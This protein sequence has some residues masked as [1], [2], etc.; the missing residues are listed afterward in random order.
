MAYKTL[1]DELNTRIQDAKNAVITWSTKHDKYY[2]LR[3][4]HK[5]TKNFP[6]PGS[7]NLR[8]PTIEM[9]I[10][11][12][13]S[14]LIGLYSNI[15][16]RVQVIPQSDTDLNKANKIEKFLDWLADY[17][18]KLLE[19]LILITD[20]MLE[21]GFCIAEVDWR[22][23]DDTRTEV[24]SLDDLSVDE[25]M[26]VF[27]LE[28]SDDMLMQALIQKLKVDTSE[29]VVG[30]NLEELAKV[31]EQI[32]SGKDKIK[33]TLKDELY[34]APVVNVIDPAHFFVNSDAGIDIQKLRFCGYEFYEP[35]ENLKKW[36]QKGIIDKEALDNIDY[37]AQTGIK[38]DKLVETTKDLH[39]GIQRLNNPSHLVKLYKIFTYYD[40]D[41]D[42]VDE[43][44]MFL[45]APEF[46]EV[47]K[48]TA[49]P[50]DH[51]K[52]P[53]IRFA[54][55]V[56]DDRWYS[57]RGI[58]AHLE[59]ISKEIDA[60]HNQKIDNQTI[61]NAPMFK[62][63][64][65]VVN[66]NLV[67]F[68]PGQGIPIPGMTPLDDALKIID[69]HNAAVDFSYER[70]EMLL[71]TVIQE[72]LGVMDY[73]LQSMINRREPR[74]ATEA[75]MQQ[76][77]MGQVFSLDAAMFT[78]SLSEIFTQILELCQQYMPERVF[79]LVTGSE[80]IEPIHMER[81]EIQGK[82][83]IVARGNDINSNPRLKLERAIGNVQVLLSPV[84]LQMG[85]VT[86]MN[87]YNIL[88][89]YLQD[90]GE[91]AWK[92][93]ISQPATQPPSVPPQEMKDLTDAEKAQVLAAK[94]I[95]PD[96]EGSALQKEAELAQTKSPS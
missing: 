24:L 23:E 16:P 17:K 15:K 75:Q 27:D 19:K 87:V 93:L 20:K 44:C 70:E 59:D 53:F 72:Y 81:D 46:R 26:W 77:S 86:P 96:I 68:I 7:S 95:Q 8:L 28:T 33:V 66:P 42:G 84:P 31:I 83:H 34:N 49:L 50:Y 14:N 43:K 13:K 47:L 76:A 2:R 78:L 54:T 52:W 22:M 36:S 71:K 63:R 64:S 88:K 37:L 5:K 3:I 57:A 89:R 91:I 55:E 56:I 65:G 74:T 51:K 73:S 21:K 85:V 60:Q 90:G 30:D 45:V 94:G 48:K 62:F 35:Y 69:N 11:K 32:R 80:G 61:R 25:A 18:I 58:P 38:Q 10:R 82:Y 67:K 1:F 12:I 40:L 79:T 6:F 92:E 9:Y 39:E 29:T 41:E 4:R